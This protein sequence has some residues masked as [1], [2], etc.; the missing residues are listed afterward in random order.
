MERLTSNELVALVSR[1]FSVRPDDTALAIIVDLPDD[2]T[3]DHDR[4]QQRRQLAQGWYEELVPVT[5]AELGLPTRLFAYRNVRHNNADLPEAAW[6]IDSLPLPQHAD[7]LEGKAT[8]TFDEVFATHSLVIAPTQF[9]A[10][11]PLKLAARSG[12]FRAATMPGFSAAMIPALR[13]DYTEINTRCQFLKGLVDDAV[14]AKVL[15]EVD[16][17]TRHE[18][19]L[20]LRHRTGHASGGLFPD[21]GVAGNLPSGETYI[22]PYEGEVA[23]DP[24]QTKGT[25]PVQFGDEVVLYSIVENRAVEI[26]GAGAK[27]DDERAFLAA[28]PAYGN[29]SELGLGVLADYGLKPTGEILLDEKLAL[30]IAFGRSDHFGG[31]VGAAQF[32]KP[33]AVVHIDRVY[34]PDTQP[35]I[36][37]VD[38]SLVTS[39]GNL[40]PIV[41]NDEYVVEFP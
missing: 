34:L 10:T 40:L 8:V 7:E 5:G 33:E 12:A 19:Y 3:P 35:R 9:S 11:A 31:Q 26:L 17:E 25:M 16:G 30:H 24:S 23:G 36:R 39:K 22:V 38:A 41:Q 2:H 28:E 32:S 1:V 20:D 4:W 6:P 21:N 27:A 29:I 13:L 14:G 18:F 37:V 15:F